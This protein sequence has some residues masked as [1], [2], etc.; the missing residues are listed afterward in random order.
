MQCPCGNIFYMS[1]D[2]FKKGQRCP[3]CGNLL[4]FKGKD[5]TIKCNSCDYTK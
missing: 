4:V 2:N 3:K 5:R 1:F